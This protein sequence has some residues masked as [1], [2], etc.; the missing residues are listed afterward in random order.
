M[1]RSVL[2]S[3]RRYS[4]RAG[5]ALLLLQLFQQMPVVLAQEEP[6]GGAELPASSSM[7]PYTIL[8][9]DVLDINFFNTPQLNQTRTVGPDGTVQLLLI[10]PAR[11]DGLSVEELTEDL[12]RRYSSQVVD[13]IISVSIQKF[14]GMA[15]YVAG[16]V[17]K[18]GTLPYRGELSVVQSIF[19]AGGFRNTARLSHVLL[20]KRGQQNEPIGTLVDVGKI[21]NDAQ[22]NLDVPV[23][24]G[25]V[26]WVPRSTIA[27]I[28]LFI[29]QFIT[30]NIPIPFT[31][32]VRVN[33][34]NR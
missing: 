14:A 2:I 32:A 3:W 20:I 27:N 6:A 13:P 22:F 12:I 15:V 5:L 19:E 29:Q 24:P 8:V 1:R 25:D 31:F 34:P 26:V 23:G 17:F 9:G 7:P 30:N 21:L 11:V 10:G 4:V 28:N 33:D 18:P 16:E